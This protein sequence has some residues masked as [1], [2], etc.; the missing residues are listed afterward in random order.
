M[1]LPVEQQKGCLTNH[2]RQTALTYVMS[3]ALLG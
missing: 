3:L 1:I 2:A